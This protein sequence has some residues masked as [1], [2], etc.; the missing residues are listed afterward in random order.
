MLRLDGHYSSACC[1]KH[2]HAGQKAVDG[3]PH[4]RRSG[5]A[6]RARCYAFSTHYN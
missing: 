6:A 3:G 4:S 5:H 1:P 2:A